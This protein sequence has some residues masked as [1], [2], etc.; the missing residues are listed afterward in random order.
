MSWRYLIL[1]PF[2]VIATLAGCSTDEFSHSATDQ[3]FPTKEEAINQ[4]LQE[5]P[6]SDV[7]YIKTTDDDEI[8]IVRSG[9][10][11]YSVYGMKHANQGF[12]VVK[13]TATLSLHN[14]IAGS[15]EFTTTNGNDYTFLVVKK[16]K[17]DELDYDTRRKYTISPIY[18]GDAGIAINKGHIIENDDSTLHESVIQLTETLQN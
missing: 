13:L 12:L 11:Q 6:R 10:H 8:F 3:T 16:D 7:E 18:S 14:T 5:N 1:L 2:L 4:F 9:N 15:G 17:V